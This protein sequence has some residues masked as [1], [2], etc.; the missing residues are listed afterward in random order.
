MNIAQNK[1]VFS[2]YLITSNIIRRNSIKTFSFLT[3]LL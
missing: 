3:L 1:D 2:L